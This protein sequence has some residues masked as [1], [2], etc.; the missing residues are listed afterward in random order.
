[1]DRLKNMRL[2][3]A[4]RQAV[5]KG[6]CARCHSEPAAGKSGAQLYTAVCGNCHDSIHRAALVPDLKALAH[7]TSPEHWRKWIVE[8]KTGSMMP[9]FAQS[10]GGP[11]ENGQ[12]ESLVQ[13]LTET[14]TRKS[15]N[16]GGALPDGRGSARTSN[17]SAKA[18]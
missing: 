7:P 6:E 4:D 14:I 18:Q 10:A 16:A 5:F 13:F 2:A 1:M 17:Q 8:G 11:L 9:A 15:P 3:M 12:I